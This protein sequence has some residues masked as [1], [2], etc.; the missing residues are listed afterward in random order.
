MKVIQWRART[1][2]SPYDTIIF[3]AIL[4]SN[5]DIIFQYNRCDATRGRGQFATVGIEDSTGTIG[6]QYL[7]DGTPMGNLLSAG[8]AIRFYKYQYANDVGVDVILSPGAAHLINTQMIPAARVKN[9]GTAA[10][11]FVVRCSII[12]TAGTVRY[13][14]QQS[15]SNLAGGDTV[16]KTFGSWTPTTADNLIVY[17]T[18]YLAGDEYPGNDQR[19]RTCEVGYYIVIGTGTTTSYTNPINR[20]YNY[21]ASEAIY[22]QLEIGTAGTITNIGYY[23]GSGTDLNPID[24]VY[25]YLKHTTATSLATGTFSF[26]G[27]TLVYAGQYPNNVTEGWLA[28][29]LQT[30]FVYDGTSNLQILVLKYYQPY[31]STTASPNWRYTST[32]PTYL[33]RTYASD[34]TRPAPLSSSLTA[35][36]NRPNIRLAIIPP[37]PNDVGVLSILSPLSTQAVNVPVM[38]KA[39]VKN[40]GTANQGS[41][42]VYC[43]IVGPNSVERYYDSTEV[44]SLVSGAIDTVEFSSWIPSDAELDTVKIWTAL[45]GDEYPANDLMKRTT[46]VYELY[47]AAVT[48]ITRPGTTEQKRVAFRPQV[49]VANNGSYNADVPV[50]AEIYSIALTEGFEST[51]F[52][53][54]G[55]D[56]SWIRGTSTANYWT[57][58]P[59][60]SSYPTNVTP[61]TGSKIA[62]YNSYS[63]PDGNAYR[64]RTPWIN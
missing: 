35:T 10:N 54:V 55:W 8:R 1:Y 50:I 11:S 44:A 32:S 18:T 43:K 51:T 22:R 30:P 56:T 52:P 38:P 40:F 16:T 13:V 20:Y 34:G 3:Q 21:S 58:G 24:S 5:G 63:A 28:V 14:N 60:T 49:T 61:H 17:F 59:T 12:N 57:L 36:Y 27:Y 45:A 29:D 23:K 41:F 46:N 9:F 37:A 62:E 6:L 42:K 53:P 15:V 7:F 64:L 48:A 4:K 31:I 26:D 39:I 2:A 47:D 33:S 19:T 25:I